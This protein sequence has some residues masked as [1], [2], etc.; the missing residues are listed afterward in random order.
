MAEQ[1]VPHLPLIGP[2]FASADGLQDVVAWRDSRPVTRARLLKDILAVSRA[3][4]DH[5]RVINICSDRY[6]FMVGFA[7]AVIR[8]Q[9]TLMPPSRVPGVIV[10]IAEEYADCYLMVDASTADGA[11]PQFRISVD[12]PVDPDSSADLPSAIPPVSIEQVVAVL[13]TSG[14]TGK[15][16]PNPK[17]WG[18]L[19]RG[20]AATAQAIL[21]ASRHVTVVTTVPPQHMYGFETTMLLPLLGH[22]ALQCDRPLFPEDVRQTL[23]MTPEPRLLITTPVHL[24]TFVEFSGDMPPVAGIVCATAPLSLQLAQASER[25][26]NAPLTEVFGS[27]ETAVIAVRRTVSDEPWKVI[28][29]FDVEPHQEGTRVRARHFPG[30]V[31]LQDVIEL[32]G[33]RHFRLVGRNSDLINIAGKRASLGDL[34]AKLLSIAGVRDGVVFM[35]DRATA[36]DSGSAV[37]RTAALVV[38]PGMTREAILSAMRQLIDPAFLPR[39]LMLVDALPRNE[40]SKL[41]RAALLTLLAQHGRDTGA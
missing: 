11:L 34:N 17:R 27:T 14:S 29:L 31:L 28:E 23:G 9:V 7:A 3:L 36:D 12:A 21:P 41:P 25:K 32:V 15:A 20:A 26:F 6:L 37:Q 35:P 8:G 24:R 33:D 4:P 1:P 18:T 40:T 30:E 13:F 19:V 38:A 2:G 5:A 39:P 10:A 16:M 22:C